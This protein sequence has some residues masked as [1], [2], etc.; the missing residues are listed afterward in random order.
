MLWFGCREADTE[1]PSALIS[2]EQMPLKSEFFAGDSILIH[3]KGNI[4]DPVH[5]VVSNAWG[6]TVLTPTWKDNELTFRFPKAFGQRAGNCH[7]ALVKNG[8]I[9]DKGE[10]FIRPNPKKGTAMESYLGPQSIIAGKADFSM[11]VTSPTDIYDNPLSDSTEIK[12]YYQRM[13]SAEQE[14]VHLKN[15]IGWKNIHST[16]KSGRI[17]VTATCN[18]SNSKELST[19]VNPA[20]PVDF[21]IAYKR[22]HPYADGNQIIT[23]STDA[24]LDEFGNIQSDGTLV[25]FS[26]TDTKGRVLQTIGTTING[27]AEALLLHPTEAETWKVTAY[28]TGAAKSNTITV[29]FE[30]AL[31][32]FTLSLSE[33]G[34]TLNIEEMQSFMGQWIPDGMPI[35]ISIHDEKG[36][37]LDSKRTT[38]RLGKA[39]F[40]MSKD[41]YPN[42]S[43]TLTLELAG[44]NKKMNVNLK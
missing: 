33:N 21:Q 41:F 2:Y 7:W 13:D 38:S 22:I 25:S 11:F 18:H 24:I 37:L 20:N 17:L 1:N 34:R 14:S 44:M 42:G 10:I 15:L 39:Q 26:I 3:F 28:I 4:T 9:Y 31:K 29:D 19:L 12:Y 35:S 30:A 43:Y 32:D 27:V 6:S 40:T 23:F 36:T 5:L 16:E 8:I